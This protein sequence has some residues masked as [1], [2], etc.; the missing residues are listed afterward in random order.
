MV[1]AATQRRNHSPQKRKGNWHFRSSI[2]PAPAGS[3]FSEP[4]HLWVTA[5]SLQVHNNPLVK[6]QAVRL[7]FFQRHRSF[8]LWEHEA[9]YASVENR[10]WWPELNYKRQCLCQ[11]CREPETTSA[12]QSRQLLNTGCTLA[13]GKNHEVHSFYLFTLVQLSLY[14]CAHMT[15]HS[16]GD[17]GTNHTWLL[18]GCQGSDSDCQ[19]YT[20]S[21]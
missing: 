4:K 21:A 8:C 15:R 13:P 3:M 7:V 11:L 16:W 18:H 2:C 12:P 6:L 9:E 20:I 1:S 19:S 14:R 10:G 5:L 17:L